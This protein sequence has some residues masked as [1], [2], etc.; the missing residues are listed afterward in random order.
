M[1]LLLIENQAMTEE[2]ES[3]PH[4]VRPAEYI[5][6]WLVHMITSTIFPPFLPCK[7]QS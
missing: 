6:D 3:M 7:V 2:K 5:L 1:L 4:E